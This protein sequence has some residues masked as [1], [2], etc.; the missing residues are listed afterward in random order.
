MPI[1]QLDEVRRLTGPSLLWDKPGAIIDVLFEDIT[2]SQV[3]VCLQTWTDKLL[4]EFNWQHESYAYRLHS[5]GLNFAISAPLDSLYSACDLLELAW[6]CCVCELQQQPSPDWQ[7]TLLNIKSELSTE[8]NPK[9][10]DLMQAAEQQQVTCLIDDDELSLGMGASAQTWPICQLPVIEQIRWSQYHDIPSAL[11]TGTNGKSTSVRLAATIAKAAGICA[12]LTS[13]DFIRV[14]DEIIDYGDYSGPGGARLLL[15]DTRCEIA[16]LEVARGGIL[17]RGLPVKK[18]KAAL[19]TNVASDHLGQYGINTVVELA[20]TKFVVA[21]ALDQQ[22]MLVLNADDPLVI[23]QAQQISTPICWFSCDESNTLIQQQIQS[24]GPAVF[25]REG[26]I[27]YHHKGIFEFICHI[28]TAPMT[29]NGAAWHNVQNALGVVGLAK[30]LNLPHFAIVQG[31]QEFGSDSL[32]NPGRGNIYQINGRQ[33]IVDFAHNEHGMRAV[34]NMAIQ[35]KAKRYIVMFSHAGDRS[36]EDMQHLTQAVSELNAAL[37]IPAELEKYL[38]GREPHAVP[39]LSRQFLL[40]L[41]VLPSQIHIADSPLLGAQQALA[42]ANQ[43]DVILMFVLD[44]RQAI[45]DWLLKQNKS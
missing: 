14:G 38:R 10:L 2:Q 6:D 17:R 30:T 35:L 7:S 4:M 36:N 23:E 41:G 9:L 34:I 27:F 26:E 43:G 25:V 37:Y 19:I 44:Q 40:D 33:V 42:E 13:T 29:L 32:D 15:R 5:H 3:L 11:I 21:K 8:Q 1:L 16:F 28:N 12:G 18:V 24:G 39:A 20:E 45:H 31:L 22:G